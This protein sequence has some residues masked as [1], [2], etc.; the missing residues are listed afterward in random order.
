VDPIHVLTGSTCGRCFYLNK[1]AFAPQP[2]GTVGNLG[3]NSVLTPAYWDVDLALS[4]QFRF[5]ERHV[6]EV[7]AD[8][9]NIANSFVPAFPGT[10]GSPPTQAATAQPTSGAVP[11]FAAWN[12]NQFGQILNAFPTRKIQFALKYTF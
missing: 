5:R 3:W 10:P 8:A 11:A 7:R 9:F 12:S 1:A 4:R 6:F 2:L